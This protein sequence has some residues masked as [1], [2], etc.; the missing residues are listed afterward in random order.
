MG[1]Q[2]DKNIERVVL[3]VTGPQH[4]NS[5]PLQS[6]PANG[7]LITWKIKKDTQTLTRGQDGWQLDNFILFSA[8][9]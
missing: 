9:S 5:T 4:A 6:P 1:G 2:F 8:N 7:F 3:L